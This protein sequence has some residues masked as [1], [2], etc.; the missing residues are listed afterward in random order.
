MQ[1]FICVLLALIVSMSMSACST[2]SSPV[3]EKR[4][5]AEE[6]VEDITQEEKDYSQYV[7]AAY[8]QGVWNKDFDEKI[9]G[10]LENISLEGEQPVFDI[11]KAVEQ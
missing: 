11:V 7:I 1:K 4:S 3:E 9:D 2:H 5:D 6:I 8:Q 10:K